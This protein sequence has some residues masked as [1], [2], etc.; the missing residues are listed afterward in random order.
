MRVLIIGN[1]IAGTMAAK[2][3]RE[4]N[5]EIEIC[6][7]SDER[8]PYY[9]RP[10]LIEFLAGLRPQEKIY[11]FPEDWN[12]RQKIDVFL[13][14]PVISVNPEKKEVELYNGKEEKYDV[15]ILASGARASRPPIKGIERKG[16]FT[17]RTLDDALSILDYLK[18]HHQ[19]VVIGGGLL[20]LEIARALKIRGA[21]VTVIEFFDRL[22]PRQ[23][24][25]AA[26]SVLKNQIEALGIKVLLGRETEEIFGDQEVKGVKIKGGEVVEA[27]MVLIAAGIK[28][29][30]ELAQKA[31][32]KVNKGIVVDD[33]LRTS[34]Q[35]IFAVGDVIEHRGRLYGIIPAAFD[36]ARA[37]AYNIL[38]QPK[39]YEGTI[40]SNSLK[41]MGIALTSAGLIQGEGED[42]EELRRV[43]EEKGIYKKIVLKKGRIVGAIWMGTKKG[44]NEILRAINVQRD[45]TPWKEALLEE[46]FDFSAINGS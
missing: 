25:V 16:V 41:V 39:P 24:D 34:H 11:A 28:P 3:L 14:S 13:S 38:G 7:F 43:D 2:T 35:E 23:L 45:M 33:Y 8:Y 30:L 5:Q 19:T 10:N 22:L 6:L 29:N 20:G 26:A 1:G 9:P 44:V 15:L 4:L 32:L 27:D 31:G 42:F 21:E 40:P 12:V 17:L 37:A 46:D 18:N 36:Q